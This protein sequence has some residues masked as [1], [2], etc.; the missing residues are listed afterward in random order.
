[1]A[2][3]ADFF[4]PN[5]VS[6]RS[7]VQLPLGAFIFN[8]HSDNKMEDKTLIPQEESPMRVI[9][10][11]NTIRADFFSALLAHFGTWANIR[12]KFGICKSR[13]EKFR[14]GTI[15]IPY[16]LYQIFIGYLNKGSKKKIKRSIVL[17]EHGWGRRKGGITTYYRHHHI[18]E[19]GRIKGGSVRRYHFDLN[20]L[21]TPELCELIGA[22]IGDGFTNRYQ[23][24]C[25]IQFTGN[26]KLDKNYFNRLRLII[27]NLSPDSNPKI[28]EKENTLR[29]T[30]NSR[31]FF[32]LL[33]IRFSL[34]PG[35]KV[36]TIKI[37][38]EIYSSKNNKLVLRCISGIF[39]TDGG[40]YFDKRDKYR[41]PYVRIELH[42]VSKALI[43][44]AYTVLESQGINASLAKDSSRIQINGKANCR[45]FMQKIGLANPRHLEKLKSVGIL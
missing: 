1:V 16:P 33:T 14:D 6:C 24:S 5:L 3:A 17:K 21:L 10:E 32:E 38:K 41:Q 19:E 15:S 44:Q 4:Q 37:P 34:K 18:F 42:M 20:T 25:I 12:K 30:V 27:K 40:V 39:D 43:R 35:K 28:T 11:D 9:I 2:R 22:F 7:R 45:E 13:L 23:R 31:E 36:Y 29:L 26:R 8:R